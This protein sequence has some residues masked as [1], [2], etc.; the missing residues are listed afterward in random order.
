MLR[1]CKSAVERCLLTVTSVMLVIMLALAIW[2]VVSRY[3]LQAPA[4]YTEESLRFVMIW[5]GLLG[6]A[7]A[8]G[9]DQH[10][11][12]VF[13]IERATAAGKRRLQTM[14]GLIVIF[15][16]TIILLV[17]GIKMV[18]TGMNQISPILN[19]RMGYIYMILPICAVLITALQGINLVLLWRNEPI[20]QEPD[21]DVDASGA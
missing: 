9:T 13:L 11:R 16:S 17:G 20:N 2:Q 21:V 15:F 14:N 7:Y 4:I 12:L 18:S 3:I 10:L 8:F 1:A 6:S 5:M 19:V